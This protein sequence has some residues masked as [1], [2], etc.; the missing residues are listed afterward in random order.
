MTLEATLDV[1]D[2][3]TIVFVFQVVNAGTESVE[4][5][6]RTGHAADLVIYDAETGETVWQWSDGRMF[7]QA[8][9]RITLKSEEA[10][11]QEFVWGDPSPGTYTVVATCEADTSVEA[12][13]DLSI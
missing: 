5:T 6:F 9:Q 8:V 4:L 7:T 2:D 13:T 11:K 12:R 10:F 1:T 3:D